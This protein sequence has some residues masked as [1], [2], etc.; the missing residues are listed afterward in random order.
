METIDSN[1]K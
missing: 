1:T